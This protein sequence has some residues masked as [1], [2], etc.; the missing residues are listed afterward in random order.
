MKLRRD[1]RVP[2]LEVTIEMLEHEKVNPQHQFLYLHQV[3]ESGN[4]GMMQTER[5]YKVERLEIAENIGKS[6]IKLDFD[7]QKK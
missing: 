3:D 1:D 7:R 4:E 6:Y 5:I 2:S